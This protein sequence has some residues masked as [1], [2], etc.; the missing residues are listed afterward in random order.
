L[1]GIEMTCAALLFKA[2]DFEHFYLVLAM[3]EEN[4]AHLRALAPGPEEAAKVRLL[5]EFDPQA[6]GPLAVPDPYFGGDDG[7]AEVFDLV[8]AACRG[9]L[10]RLRPGAEA[11]ATG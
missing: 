2:K 4:A 8:H 10:D 3:D 9:L 5:R 6:R 11:A 7:F 1:R